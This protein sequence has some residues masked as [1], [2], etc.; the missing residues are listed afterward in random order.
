MFKHVVYCLFTWRTASLDNGELER[1]LLGDVDERLG[2]GEPPWSLLAYV[3]P[4]PPSALWKSIS[5]SSS[6]SY[7][8]MT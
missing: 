7:W 1:L 5:E 3:D 8:H 2:V 4:V 6:S